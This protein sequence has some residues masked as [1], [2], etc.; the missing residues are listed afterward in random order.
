MLFKHINGVLRHGVAAPYEAQIN[1]HFRASY[2]SASM[3]A[4]HILKLN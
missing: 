4:D 3:D 1:R 2:H